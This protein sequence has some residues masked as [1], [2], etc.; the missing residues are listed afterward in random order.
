MT[1]YVILGTGVAG[2]AA[3]QAI[4]AID[5]Q[6]TITFISEDPHWYY[7]RPGLAY[8]L[9]GEIEEKQLFPFQPEDYKALNAHFWQAT[10]VKILPQE[11]FVALNDGKRV[12]YDRLLISV[13]ASA[14]RLKVPGAELEGVVK[15]D[16]MEDARQIVARSK[17][18]R[19]A[20]VVGGGIT[21]LE[22]AE[23]LALRRLKVHL[24]IRTNRYWSNVLDE[25]ESK[26]IQ[27]RLKED[28]IN[29][30]YES[31]LDEVLGKQGKVVGVR[32]KSGQQIDCD[33]LAY[34]IGIQP[35]IKLAK[36]SGI[37]CDR[38]ILADEH[39]RTNQPNIFAAGDVAQ[40]YDPVSGRSV[41]DSL[42]TPAREQG[43]IAGS[44]MAGKSL[45]YIKSVS[46][47]VTRL[48]GLTTTIIG[49]VGVGTDS[50]ENPFVIAR[51]D[52][53]T[54]RDM[55]DAI[56]AQNGF[57]INH[58]RL[59]LTGKYIV[60]AI[61]MGDQKLSSALQTIVRDRLDISSIREQLLAPNAP[62]ADILAKFWTQIYNSRNSGTGSGAA[63]T[64][65]LQKASVR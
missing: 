3:A 54:W 46:F 4:R 26:I 49:N 9:T 56:I 16:H 1:N 51:G 23:G 32:L 27:H 64:V 29:V 22:L 2:I 36:E 53:E 8:Y 48:A 55:P 61:V 14:S 25:A 15:L 12:P 11:Q 65:V 40:V 35:R 31:E 33:M 7:S 10:A 24:L 57:D 37:T 42:W 41:I 58:V 44:N 21:A 47:N 34:A 19:S 43:H 5:K 17:R 45:A 62:I 18:A 39:L 30:H 59:M 38:G 52:S 20:V 60:G 13:G 6:G 28:R 50:V 63:S